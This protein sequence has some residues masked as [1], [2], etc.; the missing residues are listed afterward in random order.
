MTRPRIQNALK[1][2]LLIALAIF[3]YTRIVNGSLYFYIAERFAWMTFL[4]VFGLIIVGLSYSLRKGTAET[5]EHD[6]EHEHDHDH[7]HT[8]DHDHHAHNHALTWGGALI[9]AIPVL[10]GISFSPQP[11][12]AAALVNREVDVT[13]VRST[14]PAAVR[15][16]AAKASTD[17][18]LLDW[19]QLFASTPDAA[20]AYAGE[21]ARVTGFVFRD[22][23][24]G[25]EQ[26][27]LTRFLVSCCVA[28]AA[29]AGVV[30]EWPDAANL[31]AD[32]WFEV[33][34]VFEAGEFAGERTPVLRASSLR[35]VEVPQ[36]PYLYP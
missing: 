5:H 32:D 16:A 19:Q 15:A 10:L 30:I 23:R 27:F 21:P 4:A 33:E 34:G 14:M 25:D 26:F 8:H 29:V 9:L 13:E 7:A 24:F 20:N 17:K 12:G 1:A 31:S 36:Q 28:D 6:H 11:L 2:L 3:L 35:P 18:N 22:D